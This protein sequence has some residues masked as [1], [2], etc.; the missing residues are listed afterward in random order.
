MLAVART[1]PIS[2][3]LRPGTPK[4]VLREIKSRYKG[5][6][7]GERSDAENYFETDIYKD[8]AKRLTPDVRIKEL[9]GIHNMTQAELAKVLGVAVQKV[10]DFETGQ[11][12]VSKKIAK[13]L[14]KVFKSPAGNFF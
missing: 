3:W 13:K 12:E 6:M 7:L 5:F 1:R 2:L 10:S 11:R 8:S 4:R 9:R 14:E